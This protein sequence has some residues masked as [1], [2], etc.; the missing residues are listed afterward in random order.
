MPNQKILPFLVVGAL[1]FTSLFFSGCAS[2]STAEGMTAAP[3]SL[4]QKHA[5][6]VS[7]SVTGGSET[8]AAAVSQ[9]SNEAFAQA[10]TSSIENSGL[11]SK[12]L[13][14]A[15]GDYQLD[16]SIVR[17]D[18]PMFGL[19]L[20]VTI[21]TDWLLKHRSD[22]NVVWKKAIP[23]TYTA[24]PGDAFVAATRLRLANEGA[25]KANIT[26]AIQEMAKLDLK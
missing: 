12:V 22:G 17:V 24:T 10:L 2:P 25:A 7:I 15:T 1:A 5:Q 23:T 8:N 3:M 26:E 18:Q 9:I 16:V 6:T 4:G 21:E 13:T 14:V 20:T 19:N 11:F